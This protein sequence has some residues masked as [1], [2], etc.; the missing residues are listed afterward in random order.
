MTT[1]LK[2]IDPARITRFLNLSTR[3]ISPNVTSALQQARL[4]ALSRQKTRSHI[5]ALSSEQGTIH[6]LFSSL[7]AQHWVAAGLLVA[8]FVIGSGY[9]QHIQQEEQIADT[10]VAILTDDLPIDAFV[11]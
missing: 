11:D 6:S 8:I 9:W 4:K 3:Q 7:S 2:Q 5:L 10:D 1:D